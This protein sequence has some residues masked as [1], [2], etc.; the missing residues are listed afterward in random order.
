MYGFTVDGTGGNLPTEDGPWERSGN[1]V[2]LGTTMA[3]TSPEIAQEIERKGYALVKGFRVSQPLV[4]RS[5]ST[6]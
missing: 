6:P 1:A 4:R 2:P 3:S 5:D